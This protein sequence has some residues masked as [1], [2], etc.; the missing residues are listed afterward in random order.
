[1]QIE[2]LEWSQDYRSAAGEVPCDILES[3]MAHSID[4][5]LERMAR[6]GA[7]GRRNGGY[8][9]HLLSEPSEIELAVPRSRH[10]PL[11]GADAGWRGT[12]RKTGASAIRR[13]VLRAPPNGSASRATCSAAV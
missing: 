2:G 8:R 9:R 5:H 12:G 1:M 3:Q 10:Q 7:A 6:R 4:R 11:P 13:P